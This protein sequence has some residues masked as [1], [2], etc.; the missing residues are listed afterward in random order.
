[1]MLEIQQPLVSTTIQPD[2]LN[3]V[4]PLREHKILTAF[5]RILPPMF[6]GA[7]FADAQEFLT[8]SIE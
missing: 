3:E 1:M 7:V 6:S 2:I 5:Q 4:I 8:T